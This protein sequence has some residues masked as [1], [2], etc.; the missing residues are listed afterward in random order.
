MRTRSVLAIQTEF[1]ATPVRREH[2]C[3]CIDRAISR[4]RLGHAGVAAHLHRFQLLESPLCRCGQVETGE[5]FLLNCDHYSV[6]RHPLKRML[7]CPGLQF[8]LKN[9][10]GGGGGGDYSSRVLLRI[11]SLGPVLVYCWW[12]ECHCTCRTLVGL[13]E[14]C[15]M[16]LG[17]AM[18]NFLVYAWNK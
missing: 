7:Q 10:L 14:E 18:K 11:I 4:L 5:H 9:V 16:T 17:D 8:N 12:A 13:D 2:P 1:P 3:L 15:N 6:Q